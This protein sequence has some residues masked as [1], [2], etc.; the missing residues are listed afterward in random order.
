MANEHDEKYEDH[1]EGEYHFSDEHAAYEVDTE[2]KF[3][4]GAAVSE[5][6]L[7]NL[8]RYRRPLIAVGVLAVLM[9]VVYLTLKP[10]STDI[11]QVSSSAPKST[12]SEAV[13]TPKP[14]APPSVAPAAS[15]VATSAPVASPVIPVAS[16]APIQAAPV[17]PV[18][19]VATNPPSSV[20]QSQANPPVMVQSAPPMQQP[21]QT[22][23]AMSPDA[24]RDVADRVSA[25]EQQNAKLTNVLQIEYAQKISDYDNQSAAVQAKLKDLSARV[26][27][28]E[29][30]L[31]QI[32]QLLQ[33]Q[34][35]QAVGAS[36]GGPMPSARAAEP[37]QIYTVQAIIPG[38][39]WLKSDAGDTVTVAEGDVLRDYG[40]V[41]KIDPY[42][43]VVNI[44][45]GNKM[46]T[47][48]YGSNGD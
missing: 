14:I 11:S 39:A 36:A 19:S 7:S 48:S 47:L 1:D 15:S 34:G 43:G 20:P 13:K 17:Q 3:A 2:T 25:L 8:A 27:N 28:M 35:R 21:V 29:A 33:G 23:N 22:M 9:V 5:S 40:R 42:D 44:D 12:I 6:P 18:V 41:T 10:S 24:N 37:K 45:T 16:P 26:A 38:R 30:A 31:N 46:V 4:P 32:T